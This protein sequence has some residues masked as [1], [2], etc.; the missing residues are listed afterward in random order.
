MDEYISTLIKRQF[1]LLSAGAPEDKR[2]AALAAASYLVEFADGQGRAAIAMEEWGYLANIGSGVSRFDPVKL[3]A[4]SASLKDELERLK[5]GAETLEKEVEAAKSLRAFVEKSEEA[6]SRAES[7][8]EASG[9]SGAW[10]VFQR[11]EQAEREYSKIDGGSSLIEAAE[12]AA[13]AMEDSAGNRSEA[14]GRLS[15]ILGGCLGEMESWD[16]TVRG[17][18]ESL[19]KLGKEL[20]EL[21]EQHKEDLALAAEIKKAL[22][23]MGANDANDLEASVKSV[24]EAHS[25][26]AEDCAAMFDKARA[27]IV[28]RKKEIDDR[29]KPC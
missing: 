4:K 26:A 27:V 28:K 10:E 22:D 12:A 24:L 2:K 3:A 23:G 11:Y 25:K 16:A 1:D 15:A 9:V 17:R 18:V 6:K 5:S 14:A 13:K 21:E 7:A 8:R 19:E 29:Q 20:P